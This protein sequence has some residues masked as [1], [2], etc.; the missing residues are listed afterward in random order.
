MHKI[1]PI[2]ISELQKKNKCM[3]AKH[4]VDI[5]MVLDSNAEVKTMKDILFV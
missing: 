5:C 1:M 2:K 3:L 4:H